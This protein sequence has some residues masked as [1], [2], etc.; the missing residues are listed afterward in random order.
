MKL[1]GGLDEMAHRRALNRWSRIADAAPRL[2]PFSL[3]ALRGQARILRSSLDKVIALAD[4]GIV[5]DHPR[6]APDG[7]VDWAWR[8]GIW[9]EAQPSPTLVSP[10]TG[11]Q[12]GY[13]LKLFHD[14]ARSEL[15][16]RQQ[17]I[18]PRPPMVALDVYGFD[19]SFLSLVV[20]LPADRI[21]GLGRHHI[22]GVAMQARSEREIRVT[23]RLNVQNGPNTEQMVAE[24]EQN[25]DTM[26]LEFDL[27][28][29]DINDR[30]VESVWIDLIFDRPAMNR[31]EI[32]DLLVTRR[33]RAEI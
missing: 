26:A 24:M 25:G 16:L 21:A 15:T 12:L 8:P 14:C 20:D 22:I 32:D 33:V 17:I 30:R 23:A 9:E 11:A 31:I 19:G 6:L 1:I 3:R 2:D 13:D 10:D 28:Y 27:A 7:P 29:S 4:Q 5:W 18:A